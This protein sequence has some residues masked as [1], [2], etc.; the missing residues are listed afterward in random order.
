MLTVKAIFWFYPA[1]PVKDVGFPSRA[2]LFI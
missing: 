1:K 2:G